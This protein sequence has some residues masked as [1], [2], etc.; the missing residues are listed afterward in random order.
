MPVA[1]RR[2]HVQTAV[3]HVILH[4]VSHAVSWAARHLL[5]EVGKFCCPTPMPF[6][7]TQLEIKSML[8]FNAAI[9]QGR[10]F[11]LYIHV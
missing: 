4:V 9:A 1:L 10:K 3:P 8:L 2:S 6:E 7:G 5:R 11:Y